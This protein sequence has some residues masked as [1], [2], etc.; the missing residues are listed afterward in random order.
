MTS[1]KWAYLAFR[2]GLLLSGLATPTVDLG[3]APD[4][5]LADASGDNWDFAIS[6]ERVLDRRQSKHFIFP[7]RHQQSR[8]SQLDRRYPLNHCFALVHYSE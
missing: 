4:G 2:G 7:I 1:L 8:Y 6:G 3:S 5:D